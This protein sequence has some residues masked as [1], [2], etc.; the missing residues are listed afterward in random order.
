MAGL[1]NQCCYSLKDYKTVVEI[2]AHINSELVHTDE[3]CN[4][5]G[6][7]VVSGVQLETENIKIENA[8]FVSGW[9][10]SVNPEPEK[11]EEWCNTDKDPPQ[12]QF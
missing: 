12:G 3:N 5:S 7:S 1:Y 2:F 11:E 6:D 9:Q 4:K 8:N 10:P